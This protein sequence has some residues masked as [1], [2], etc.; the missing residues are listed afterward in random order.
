MDVDAAKD[1][2]NPFEAIFP[3]PL[4][5]VVNHAERFSIALSLAELDES[6]DTKTGPREMSLSETWVVGRADEIKAFVGDVV[7]DWSAGALST[8]AASVTIEGYLTSLHR[9]MAIGTPLGEPT[10]CAQDSITVDFFAR[11]LRSMSY[12]RANPCAPPLVATT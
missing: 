3:D 12:P 1:E 5:G 9:F 2:H 7:R 10:C 11:G 8:S 6:R 4:R